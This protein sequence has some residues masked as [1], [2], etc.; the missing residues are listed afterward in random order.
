VLSSP[1]AHSHTKQQAHRKQALEVRGRL[2]VRVF[3][4]QGCGDCFPGYLQLLQQLTMVGEISEE[5]FAGR[6]DHLQKLGA[7]H[8][9]AV[10]EDVVRKKIVATGSILVEYKF[11]H[12]CGKT[13]H[14]ED[15][16]V[17]NSVRGQHLGLRIVEFLTTFAEEAGC[18]KVSRCPHLCSLLF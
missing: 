1:P 6:V 4:G 8:H 13:G 9:V 15:V 18:Y 17:D 5:A 11:V 12:N 14:I 2:R 10:I 16:V 7:N 3:D